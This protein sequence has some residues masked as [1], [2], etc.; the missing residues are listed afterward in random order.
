M[1]SDRFC[2]IFEHFFLSPYLDTVV[3]VKGSKGFVIWVSTYDL[4]MCAMIGCLA[5]RRIV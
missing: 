4:T 1:G 3:P 2:A 5:L